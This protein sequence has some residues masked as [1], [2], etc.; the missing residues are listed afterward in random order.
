MSL[1]RYQPWD[2]FQEMEDVFNR[3]PSLPSL[4]GNKNAFVP[5]MN[6]YETK[7]AVIVEIPLAGVD[8]KDVEVSVEKGVL[9]IQGETKK[10]HEVDDKNYYRKEMRSGSF[11]RQVAL[12]VSVK[13]DKVDAQFED[14]ILKVTC[15]KS[16]PVET[17]KINV[18]IVKKDKK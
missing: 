14:G 5:A 15:P 3:F 12:P 4:T 8:P 17:K 11:F 9:V 7:D 13:E 18:R 16:A 6:M 1:I 2:P 10:E